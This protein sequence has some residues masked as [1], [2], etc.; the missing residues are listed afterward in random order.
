MKKLIILSLLISTTTYAQFEGDSSSSSLGTS[1]KQQGYA[2]GECETG[3]QNDMNSFMNKIT[4]GGF[5]N[6]DHWGDGKE[7]S[8]NSSNISMAPG[9]TLDG[10]LKEIMDIF[11]KN[12]PAGDN[13]LNFVVIGESESLQ[14]SSVRDG[15]MYPRIMMKS[16]N[17]ELMVT[18]NTDPKAK[19]YNTIEM[20]R[21]NGKQGRYEF[22]ELNFGEGGDKP[23][24][25]ASG[26]KCL[27]CH[28][29]PDPR[30]NWDTYRAWAGVVPSRDDM[31][32]MHGQNQQ[33]DKSKGMQPDAKAYL[34]FLD[35]MVADKEAGNKSRIS[36][37]DIPFDEKRQMAEYVQAAGG[38]KFSPRE[39]VDLIK[40][41]IND[42]GFYRIK[43]FPDVEEAKEGRARMAFNFD[44][45]TAEWAGPSQFA[46]DQ[47]LAQNMCKVTTDL[48][49]HPN[50]EKFKYPLALMMA[51]GQKDTS[52]FPE[53]YKKQVVD[54]YKGNN[55]QG[56]G[57]ID[58]ALKPKTAP[59]FEQLQ[60]LVLQD[61]TAS[62]NHAN[63]FKF[64]R[65][66]K[67]LQ[68]YLTEVERAPAA[69][70]AKTAK[71]Y[72][73]E[74]STPTQPKWHA[75]TDVGGVKGVPEASTDE[76]ASI[77]LL[78]EP[79]GVPVSH[80][81]LVHGKNNAYNS[82]S[83]S[84]QFELFG[85][86][87]LWGEIR[88]EAGG[89]D[90][91]ESKSKA[92]LSSP[93]SKRE[94]VSPESDNVSE[95]ALLCASQGKGI[96]QPLDDEKLAEMSRLLM[97][98]LKPDIKKSM[99]KCLTCHDTDG[100]IEFPG[101]SKFVKS[102]DEADFLNFMNSQSDYYK[103]PMVE[104]IQIK[105]G[106][107]P[108]PENDGI[109]YGGN[110]PPTDW[111]DN[112][113]YAAKHGIQ[114]GKAQETRRKQMATYLGFAAAGSS[115][116]KLKSFCEKIN[117]DSYIKDFTSGTRTQTTPSKAGRQ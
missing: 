19:G 7:K 115:K 104:V 59:T 32:E 20:M 87:A 48:K 36:M 30:P 50:F 70:A 34:S 33:F 64:N 42:K 79:M 89:C 1:C 106:L 52:I 4:G 54:F 85:S 109:D 22:Q 58:P 8:K 49:K 28:K 18:F 16:P 17:S 60:D 46:F 67:F 80:W 82:F 6:G 26:A 92:A 105:L 2:C 38:K 83:F 72:S 107:L 55:Y 101:L 66:E 21:W 90:E 84:D 110:M 37:L 56:L 31:M 76:L 24:V 111:K 14:A 77:R 93:E 13:K 97:A 117:N 74:V 12:N 3:L 44:N 108:R 88:E 51:C 10:A 75:I 35:Q 43:H 65:H 39:Q 114:P 23:H 45:K 53:E 113:D 29:S 5:T 57:D 41:Q 112:A 25:D 73:E 15:K 86:Q 99:T 81:S 100:D 102:D 116:E 61:T 69:E 11:K 9:V 27:E 91:L 96:A 94:E 98:S 68:S 40:K 63:G 78:L 95:L 62:H 47:M 103:R 71:F